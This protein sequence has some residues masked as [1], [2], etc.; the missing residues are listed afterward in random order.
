L[1]RSI[2]WIARRPRRSFLVLFLS[3]LIPHTR[4]EIQAVA[5]SLVTQGTFADPYAMPT[6]PTAHM[7]PAYP[8][9]L[10]LIYRLF[11]LTMTAGYVAWLLRLAA[12]ATMVAMLPWLAHRVGLGAEAGVV[13]GLAAAIVPRWPLG[14][15]HPAAVLLGLLLVWT[16]VRWRSERPSAG[17]ALLLG[18]A[19]GAAFHVTPSLLTVW[20]GLLLVE[21]W[22]DRRSRAWT[23][24]GSTVLGVLVACAPWTLRNHAAF[25]ELFFVRS[26]FGL[27]LRMGNHD[28]AVADLDVLDR[29]EGDSMRHPRSNAAEARLVAELGELEYM[30]RAGREALEWIRENPKRYSVLTGQRVVHFWFGSSSD[31]WRAVGSTVITL[32]AA[33]GLLRSWRSLSPGARAVLVVPIVTYPLVYYLVAYTPRYPVPLSAVLL[34]LAGA[35]VWGRTSVRDR[36]DDPLGL[37]EV[38]SLVRRVD[39]QEGEQVHP[40]VAGDR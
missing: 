39:A 40:D 28:G 4:W 6:G 15:E 9:L 14:V 31:P 22:R 18:L 27:E 34:V 33:L 25:G 19:W 13:G 16:L 29:L 20:V 35:G 12:S 38:T 7:P 2:A 8:A 24:A 17:G 1:P 3:A 11:G 5:V 30:R 36:G 26:N 23:L 21:L 37:P 32:L 10:A